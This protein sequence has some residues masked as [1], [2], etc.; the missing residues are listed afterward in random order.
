[1][2]ERRM[3]ERERRI[4]ERER[5]KGERER[6]MGLRLTGDRLLGGDRERLGDKGG[7]GE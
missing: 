7:E 6:R 1:M 3:G 4:G 2:G 5:R